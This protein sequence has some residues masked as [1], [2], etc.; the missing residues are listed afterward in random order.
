M[1]AFGGGEQVNQG[2]EKRETTLVDYST[3]QVLHGG[4]T[5]KVSNRFQSHW[6]IREENQ[7]K[8]VLEDLGMR[9]LKFCWEAGWIGKTRVKSVSFC[10]PE[11]ERE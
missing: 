7:K 9:C 6:Y 5:F 11:L 2:K 3:R 10:P 8:S 1:P 4:P